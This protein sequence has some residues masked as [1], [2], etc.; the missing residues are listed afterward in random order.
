[1][2]TADAAVQIVGLQGYVAEADSNRA[3][4][5]GIYPGRGGWGYVL[6]GQTGAMAAALAANGVIFAARLDVASGKVA[7]LTRVLMDWAV[8]TAFTTVTVAGRGLALQRAYAALPYTGGTAITPAKK[9]SD[10]PTSEFDANNGG[11]VRIATTATLTAPS[12]VP[13]FEATNLAFLSVA[14]EGAVNAVL[15]KDFWFDTAQNPP[16]EVRPSELLVIR[17]PAAMDAA[18]VWNLNVQIEYF[19]AQPGITPVLL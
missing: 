5:A 13:I 7:Y 15:H 1:M 8:S 12:P 11:D 18:G 16:A 17:N 10:H 6:N 19:E 2:G 4:R 14:G 3:L 9:R